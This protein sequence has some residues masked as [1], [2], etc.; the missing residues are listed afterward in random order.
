MATPVFIASIATLK[1]QLRLT[2]AAQPDALAMI[3]TAAQQARIYLFRV[4][5]AARILVLQGYA[6][7]AEGTTTAEIARLKAN[8]AELA[9]VRRNLL[10]TMPTLFMD[11]SGVKREVWN[12]EGMTRRAQQRELQDEIDRLQLDIDTWLA[13]LVSDDA[14]IAGDVAASVLTATLPCHSAISISRS[15]QGGYVHEQDRFGPIGLGNVLG[16]CL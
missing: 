2:G 3:D 12:E 14:E 6:Y 10:R 5:G 7:N 13:E 16:G 8:N 9:L 4:L 11:A 15:M 1:A